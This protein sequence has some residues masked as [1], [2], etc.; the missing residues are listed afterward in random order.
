VACG[1]DRAHG[2]CTASRVYSIMSADRGWEK[3]HGVPWKCNM[4]QY[5]SA[6]LALFWKRVSQ[7]V[8]LCHGCAS[9]KNAFS[10]LPPSLPCWVTLGIR[11]DDSAPENNVYYKELL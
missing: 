9:W 4:A 3:G 6:P 11:A 2:S 8:R 7:I 1:D 10:R 5:T